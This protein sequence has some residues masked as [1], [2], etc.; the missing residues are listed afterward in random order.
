V[1]NKRHILIFIAI[2]FGLAWPIV[3]LLDTLWART[4]AQYLVSHCAA[5]MMPGVACV[6]VRKWVSKEGFGDCGFAV[7]PRLPYL[8]VILAC[9]SLWGVPRLVDV[10]WGG[11][12]LRGYTTGLLVFTAA[13]VVLGLVPAFG[14]ELGWRGYLLPKLLP[15]GTRKALLSH[16]TIWGAWHWPILF[17]VALKGHLGVAELVSGMVV[18]VV[19]SAFLGVT[20]GWLRLRFGSLYLATFWHAYYDYFRDALDLWFQP[21]RLLHAVS[22]APVLVIMG[23]GIFLLL[24]GKYA[25]DE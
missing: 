13:D 15:M 10:Y 22:A 2:S 23:V 4:Y 6:I 25:P 5:M 9:L 7:G 1:I 12:Q 16:G 3:V 20:A 18:M 19:V 8:I 17:A 14:E 11:G 21:G 24:R